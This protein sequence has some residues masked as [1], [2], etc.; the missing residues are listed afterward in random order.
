METIVAIS[1][2]AM[3]F[4]AAASFLWR[5]L[6]GKGS[7]LV[8]AGLIFTMLGLAGLLLSHD[9]PREHISKL[10]FSLAVVVW[11]SITLIEDIKEWWAYRST[12]E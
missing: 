11:V 2:V 8:A 1:N 10:L 6:T 4:L 3:V 5:L 12:S 9:Q 7:I